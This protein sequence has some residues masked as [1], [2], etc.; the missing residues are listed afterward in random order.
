[1]LQTLLVSGP[2]HKPLRR[3]IRSLL[4]H[5]PI[6]DTQELSSP[7]SAGEQS[8]A[9]REHRRNPPALTRVFTYSLFWQSSD[10]T[11]VTGVPGF[12]VCDE[13]VTRGVS[14]TY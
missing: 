8:S 5:S 11:S 7:V 4:V 1:M 14:L 12:I 3:K 2:S 9:P 10:Q 6:T 13:V